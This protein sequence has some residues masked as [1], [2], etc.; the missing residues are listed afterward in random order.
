MRYSD[1]ENMTDAEAVAYFGPLTLSYIPCGDLENLLGWAGLATR[2]PVTGA[3]EGSLI[4]FMNGN[5]IPA[6]SAGLS[7]LF[8]HLNKP[9]STG[10]DT[11]LQPWASSM[12]DLFNGLIAVGQV[13]AAFKADVVALAGGYANEDLDEAAVAV[14]RAD[15]IAEEEAAVAAEAQRVADEAYRATQNATKAKYDEL[16]NQHIAPLYSAKDMTDASWIAALQ[17]MSSNWSV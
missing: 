9:R 8:S 6:L 1:I 17:A 13:D 5:T 12:E 15:G 16:Y 2:N 10:V 14:I 11:H 3:W 4:D 7:D